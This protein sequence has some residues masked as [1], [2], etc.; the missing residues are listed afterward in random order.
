MTD[1]AVQK[2]Q[3]KA[4]RE[5]Q[6]ALLWEGYWHQAAL[7][8]EEYQRQKALLWAECERQLR[9]IEGKP[10]QAGQEE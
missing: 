4:E 2:Q 8:W 3:A 10:N 7:L 6:K 1:K 9:E 5:R